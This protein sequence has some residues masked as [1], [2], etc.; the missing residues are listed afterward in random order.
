MKYIVR[1]SPSRIN[2][3]EREI[4]TAFRGDR[5]SD[6]FGRTCLLDWIIIILN[7]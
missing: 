1:H 5:R 7:R 3:K 2:Q 6:Y 4:K